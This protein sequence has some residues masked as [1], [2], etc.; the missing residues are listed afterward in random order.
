[1]LTDQG[2]QVLDPLRWRS[3]EGRDFSLDLAAAEASGPLLDEVRRNA[4]VI[5]WRLTAKYELGSGLDQGTPSLE[6]ANVAR[7]QLAL[8]E[9][10][11]HVR[12]LD[13]VVCGGV[14]TAAR[15]MK[16]PCGAPDSP[17]HRYISCPLLANSTAQDVV[18][19]QALVSGLADNIIEHEECWWARAIVPAKRF[20]FLA[21]S[22]AETS[23]GSND[24]DFEEM[25]STTGVVYP[26]GSGGPAWAP[27]TCKRGGCGSVVL[28]SDRHE[29]QLRISRVSFKGSGV[30]GRQ[31]V[32]RDELTAVLRALRSTSPD[33]YVVFKPDAMYTVNG[34][35]RRDLADPQ[36]ALYSCSGDLWARYHHHAS[37][38]SL[39]PSASHTKAHT[40]VGKIV[41][42]QSIPD[43]DLIGN[44]VADAVAGASAARIL[45]SIPAISTLRKIE[46][47]T[48]A[49]ARRQAAFEATRW[50]AGPSMAP[51]LAPVVEAAPPELSVIAGQLR[52]RIRE[53]G[54][55]LFVSGG[56]TRCAKCRRRTR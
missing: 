14:W 44:I 43:V 47:D 7:A 48:V 40:E 37:L 22:E 41:V 18:R 11:V 6:L 24:A 34:I 28:D 5:T 21:P 19:T 27:T 30:E 16:C 23:W 39:P 55:E 51:A 45:N 17:H 46:A 3:S 29:G 31:T 10:W 26:D 2:W 56:W 25:R 54:H 38:L 12:A 53:S 35:N 13:A 36:K 42:A 32:P 1:M 49:I 20:A 8:E 9:L 52:D 15:G 50:T 4:E 33:T